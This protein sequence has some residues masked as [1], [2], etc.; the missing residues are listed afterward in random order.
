MYPNHKI[1]T[2]IRAEK[3]NTSQTFTSSKTT[4]SAVTKL[5]VHVMRRMHHE[6]P[7]NVR[8]PPRLLP[9]ACVLPVFFQDAEIRGAFDDELEQTSRT[10]VNRVKPPSSPCG[11]T[12]RENE[13]ER[14]ETPMAWLSTGILMAP[15]ASPPSGRQHNFPPYAR[16][17]QPNTESKKG[18]DAS[19]L[20]V[21]AS[22]FAYKGRGGAPHR[23]GGVQPQQQSVW[24]ARGVSTTAAKRTTPATF[25]TVGGRST[26]PIQ[27]V[28]AVLRRLPHS[29]P[30]IKNGQQRT[31]VR[32]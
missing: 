18:A 7:R 24:C 27:P 16:T 8:F 17:L 20:K 13:R 6:Q 29:H 2:K 14:L 25:H 15:A 11:G 26:T 9:P 3:S 10:E 21:A 4:T 32:N 23:R 1:A 5:Y 28:P 19:P 22:C 12:P 30:H 31:S